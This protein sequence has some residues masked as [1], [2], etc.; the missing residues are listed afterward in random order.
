MGAPPGEARPELM[1]RLADFVGVAYRTFLSSNK[2]LTANVACAKSSMRFRL[3]SIR[4]TPTDASQC[5]TGQRQRSQV[6]SPNWARIRGASLGSF[7]SLTAHR[8]L[9]TN[10]RWRRH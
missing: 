7:I 5:S 2:L 6:V 8:C 3:R 9:T 1:A 10:A 4:P